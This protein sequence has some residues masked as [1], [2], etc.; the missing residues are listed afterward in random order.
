MHLIFFKLNA[1]VVHMNM[2]ERERERERVSLPFFPEVVHLAPARY[3]V[4]IPTKDICTQA[5]VSG[6]D[7]DARLDVYSRHVNHKACS[8]R[9]LGEFARTLLL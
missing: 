6:R 1:T 2:F 3:Y 8:S 5:Y 7:R 4:G 9:T